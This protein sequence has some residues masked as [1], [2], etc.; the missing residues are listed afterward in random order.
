MSTLNNLFNGPSTLAIAELFHRRLGITL[1]PDL[2][3]YSFNPTQNVTINQQPFAAG[4]GTRATYSLTVNGQLPITATG[5]SIFRTDWDGTWQL[6][7]QMRTNTLTDS[8][9]LTAAS[10]QTHTCTPSKQ[11]AVLYGGLIPYTLLTTTS[12]NTIQGVQAQYP[13]TAQGGETW[14]G[15]VALRAHDASGTA[16]TITV[17]SPDNSTFQLWADECQIIKGPGSVQQTSFSGSVWGGNGQGAIVTGLSTDEDTLLWMS[18]KNTSANPMRLNFNVWI[19]NASTFV[20]PNQTLLATRAQFERDKAGAYIPTAGASASATDYTQMGLLITLP[21]NLAEGGS[22]TWSGQATMAATVTVTAKPAGSDGT[23]SSFLGSYTIGL[24]KIDIQP[25][26]PATL[27]WGGAFPF[28]VSDLANYLMGAY[29]YYLEDGEFVGLGDGSATP[30]KRGDQY[31]GTLNPVDNT[32]TLLATKG[33]WRWSDGSQLKI[34]CASPG[35]IVGLDGMAFANEAPDGTVGDPYDFTYQIVN[36]TPPFVYSIVQGAAPGPIDPNTGRIYVADLEGTEYSWVVQ[37]VDSIGRR[38]TQLETINVVIP[39]LVFNPPGGQNPT[40]MVGEY[41][42]YDLGISGGLKPYT[43][44]PLAGNLGGFATLS[45]NLHIQGYFDG[46]ADPAQTSL[47]FPWGLQVTDAQGTSIQRLFSIQV[48]DHTAAQI[49]A[50]LKGKLRSWYEARSDGKSLNDGDTWYDAMGA[51]DLEVHGV[52]QSGGT[53][54]SFFFSE[55]TFGGSS[56]AQANSAA[57]GSDQSFCVMNWLNNGGVAPGAH[58]VSRGGDYHGGWALMEASDNSQKLSFQSNHAGNNT[59]A[60]EFPTTVGNYWQLVFLDYFEQEPEFII[61]SGNY[62][63]GRTRPGP[64]VPNTTQSLTV[65]AAPDG[66]QKWQGLLAATAI[67]TD[68]VWSDERKWLYNGG[69]GR[70]FGSLGVYPTAAAVAGPTWDNTTWPGPTMHATPGQP[71]TGT[72]KLT[73]GSGKFYRNEI[74]GVPAG[75]TANFDGVDTWTISGTVK[76]GSFGLTLYVLTSDNQSYNV[77]YAIK[78]PTVQWD[79]PAK[80]QSPIVNDPNHGGDYHYAYLAAAT[81]SGSIGIVGG[82]VGKSSGK[83]AFQMKYTWGAP[84]ASNA[85]MRDSCGI[86]AIAPGDTNP[87]QQPAGTNYYVGGR[88]VHGEALTMRSHDNN[89]NPGLHSSYCYAAYESQSQTISQGGQSG[90]WDQS[91]T[92]FD[93][94][95][96]VDLDSTP[97]TIS[98]WDNNAGTTPVATLNILEALR[99]LT[100]YPSFVLSATDTVFINGG[101][102]GPIPMPAGY[103]QY[104]PFWG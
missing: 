94:T 75:V 82:D 80:Y 13:A 72:I 79:Y 63:T 73:G 90:S 104:N 21:V 47:S 24:S 76:G 1:D 83:W 51:L 17:N 54:P 23:K 32:F 86:M 25:Q 59:I 85:A 33:S 5:V 37:A 50:R 101:D 20:P 14:V 15:T 31:L 30:V 44:Q 12:N 10:W 96:L 28:A 41:V 67:F 48:S 103:S 84:A 53:G 64:I 36:G 55:L 6:S 26:L 87:W 8:G 69:N 42:D 65:G 7:S 99:G 81:T 74:L 62:I 43:V 16:A 100:W 18:V 9:D 95:V 45:S 97:M 61:N 49:T 92:S 60:D 27:T 4:D 91:V 19:G 66:T 46:V 88:P 70:P 22:L 93:I 39:P 38:L 35:S 78:A 56:Y 11:S 98:W 29:G 34:T 2:V 71:F 68:K 52:L 89:N 102:Q 3:D 77:T 58:I 40:F 57:F